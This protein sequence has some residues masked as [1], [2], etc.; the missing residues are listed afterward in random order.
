[1]LR[2]DAEGITPQALVARIAATR[3]KTLEGFH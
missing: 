2:A 3:P 1:M